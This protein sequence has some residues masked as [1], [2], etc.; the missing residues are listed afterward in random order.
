M[1]Y[2]VSLTA[3]ALALTPMSADAM[4]CGNNLVFEG[5]TRHEVRKRCG[6]PDD[7]SRRFETIYRRNNL[8]EAVAIEIEIDEWI[9][10]LGSNTLDRRLIFINGRMH[11]EEI[12]D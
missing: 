10:D 6:A 1:R 9:Y 7:S 11:K 5:M 3:A 12:V 2:F 4:R 8:N